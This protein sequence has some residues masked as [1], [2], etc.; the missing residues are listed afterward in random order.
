MDVLQVECGGEKYFE[1]TLFDLISAFSVVLSN[2]PKETFLEVI[3]EHITVEQKI[4][5]I[6]S[7][8]NEKTSFSVKH[9]FES[10]TSKIEIV[11]TFL[12]L[13]ELMKMHSIM[14]VQKELFG[15][16]VI[17]KGQENG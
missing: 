8:L 17:I 13:L 7:I 10:S 1:A 9:I 2:V 12:A 11:V 6:L 16:I 3:K 14:A 15:D 5:E 4:N